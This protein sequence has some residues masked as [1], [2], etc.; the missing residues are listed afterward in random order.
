MTDRA[1]RGGVAALP[2][3]PIITPISRHSLG[4][5]LVKAGAGTVASGANPFASNEMLAFPFVLTAPITTVNKVFWLNGS[6]AGGNLSAAIY[7]ADFTLL[8]QIASTGGASNSVP[9]VV[10]L[11]A[12]LAPG[13]YY[14][15][16]ASDNGTTNRLGRWSLATTGAGFWKM[17]GCW[18]QASITVGSL[19]ATATPVACSNIAFPLFGLITRTVFDV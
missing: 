17:A 1:V 2:T 8:V 10:S 5:A 3:S 4:G 18:R 19:P 13:L 6:A 9:Q 15:A 7:N 12:K 14:A 11:A 16:L